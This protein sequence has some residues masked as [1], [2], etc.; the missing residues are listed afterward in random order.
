METLKDFFASLKERFSSPLFSS[1]VITWLI[2]NWKIPVALFFYKPADLK[3]DKVDSYI[4]LINEHINKPYIFKWPLI[5][6]ICYT[7]FYPIIRHLIKLFYAYIDRVGNDLY[8]TINKTGKISVEKYISLR[9]RYLKNI[10]DLRKIIEQEEILRKTVDTLNQHNEIANKDLKDWRSRNN[11][12]SLNGKWEIVSQNEKNIQFELNNGRIF[13]ID[14]D[15]D[16]IGIDYILNNL[17]NQSLVIGWIFKDRDLGSESVFLPIMYH[18]DEK[19]TDFKVRD[20]LISK[21]PNQDFKI[22]RF[23]KVIQI[24]N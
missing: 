17:Q 4:Q 21:L 22:K 15:I 23:R 8:L 1:F 2:L 9:E 18:Y 11:I 5:A 3:A 20:S 14:I 19:A 24:N 10:E 12:E 16:L 7:L 13:N 6:A